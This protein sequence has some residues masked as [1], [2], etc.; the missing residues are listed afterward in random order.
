[1]STCLKP[2]EIICHRFVEGVLIL[3]FNLD[4][5]PKGD[6]LYIGMACQSIPLA[7]EAV[8]PRDLSRAK[9]AEIVS[10]DSDL[11]GSSHS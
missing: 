9:L 3:D 2:Y 10:K 5:T 8:E 11:V 4:P 7:T 6:R 1:M